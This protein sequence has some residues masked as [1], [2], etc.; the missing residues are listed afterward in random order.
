MTCCN[1]DETWS[2]NSTT[3]LAITSAKYDV[4][5]N[6]ARLRLAAWSTIFVFWQYFPVEFCK[7]SFRDPAVGSP[8][9]FSCFFHNHISVVHCTLSEQKKVDRVEVSRHR[10]A[11]TNTKREKKFKKLSWGGSGRAGQYRVTDRAKWISTLHARFKSNHLRKRSHCKHFVRTRKRSACHMRLADLG[12]GHATLDR[13]IICSLLPKVLGKSKNGAALVIDLNR[14][15]IHW[16]LNKS[17]IVLIR[18]WSG[19]E[20]QQNTLFPS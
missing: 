18:I 7:S 14:L 10:S 3:L 1:S 15:G 12:L 17:K 5:I 11:P 6:F 2:F 4:F 19:N 8:Y 9:P 13:F 20:C 16:H